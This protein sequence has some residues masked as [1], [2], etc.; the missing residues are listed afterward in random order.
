MQ[1][2]KE[3]VEKKILD[4]IFSTISLRKVIN[5][6]N[7]QNLHQPD[8]IAFAILSQFIKQEEDNYECFSED[9]DEYDEDHYDPY[10]EKILR[11]RG[12]TQKPSGFNKPSK[13]SNEL[14]NFLG[15]KEDKKIPRTEATKMLHKY[16]KEHQLQKPEDGRIINTDDKLKMLL[17]VPDDVE[18]SYFNL[19]TYLSPHFLKS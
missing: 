11:K 16:I 17:K 1:K 13:I 8:D 4:R 15:F 6:E 5:K 12:S 2:L 3:D 7:S 9:D 14:K 19:Q 18:L 10:G